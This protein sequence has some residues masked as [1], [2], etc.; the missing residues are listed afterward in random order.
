ML[1]RSLF[2]QQFRNYK[3]AYFEFSPGLNLI[4]GPNAY[5]KTSLLEAIHYLMI[6][7][8]FRPVQHHH[9]IKMGFDAFYLEA[10]FCKY[11]VDQKLKLHASTKERKII[12]NSTPLASSSHLVGLIQG[13][14][15]TP[16]DVSLVKGPPAL[17]RQFLD[18]QIAQIDPLYVHHLGRYTRAM[19]QRNHLLKQKKSKT[20][21]IWEN[22]M[23]QSAAYIVLQRRLAIK[24]IEIPCR[25]FYLY[26][27]KETE[28][29]ALEYRSSVPENRDEKEIKIF[30]LEQLEKNRN[31]E[32][33]LGQT[34]QGPHKDDLWMGIGKLDV[35]SFASEG[36]QR[37]CVAALHIG[38]WER[39]KQA[40]QDS[41]L[42]M[43]DDM[44]IS[45]DDSRRERLLKRISGFGQVFI[46]AT[47][48]HLLDSIDEPKKIFP[49]LNQI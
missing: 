16:D 12:Y 36:Q 46:T 49:L 29:L 48:P 18:I 28:N 14:I 3:E 37:S 4:C 7:R 45:L 21:E 2:L 5:G 19:R 25:D 33:I 8:S 23:A 22:E 9:I 15:M 17:R 38:E 26:L 20:I 42:F 24:E 32:M 13:V 44:G 30:Y 6:G 35:R 43:I 39:L 40:A 47:N 1:L 34:L 41:P 10:I 27:T 11:N 31:R